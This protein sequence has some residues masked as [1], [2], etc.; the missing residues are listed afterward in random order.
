M[1][2][3]ILQK[4]Y[5]AN[6]NPD[7]LCYMPPDAAT[8][9]EVGC[10]AGALGRAF[11]QRN[12]LGRYIGVEIFSE[13]ADI[14]RQDLDTVICGDVEA[15]SLESILQADE[16]IDCIVYGDVLEHMKDPWRVL[17]AQSDFLSDEGQVLACIPNVQ[18]WR[19]IG[20]LIGGQWE[21]NEK[22]VQ[23]KNHLR[24][25]TLDEIVKLF[26]QAGLQIYEII[27]RVYDAPPNEKVFEVLLGAAKELG[28]PDNPIHKVRLAASQFVVR[29]G[30]QLRP[31]PVLLHAL[32]G[33]TMVCSRVRISEPHSFCATVPG[34]KAVE[35]IS[36]VNEGPAGRDDENKVFFWQRVA[37]ESF[38][39]YEILLRRGYLMISE[40]DDHPM[41]APK[42]FSRNNFES[43]RACHAVQVS[44]EP[45]AGLMRQYNPNVAVF[46]NQI[47][48]LPAPRKYSEGPIRLFFGALNREA[49]WPEIIPVID[50]CLSGSSHEVTVIHDRKFYDALATKNK[51]FVPVCPFAQYR[52][53][54]SQTDIAF[55][56]L[57]DTPFNRMKSDLKFLE[58]A[59]NGVVALASPVVYENSIR[60]GDTGSLYRSP[61][62]FGEKL[63]LL[64]RDGELRRRIAANA[65]QWVKHNR[66]LSQ[67][68]RARLEWYQQLRSRY[69]ELTEEIYHRMN[70]RG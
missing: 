2:W 12:P 20:K 66:M 68:Y 45:L 41:V 25:F 4:K 49:D 55:L 65:Y 62:E 34:V 9:L 67:H 6:V 3:L 5:Y 7:I 44:T 70:Q 57:K 59:A 38:A 28:I 61:K 24:F 13:A 64:M 11:K 21:Y 56:P 19:V 63:S 50:K 32:L 31:Q 46:L 52:E 48:E 16:K 69:A 33:E 40:F 39:Q 18:H 1:G 42:E 15:I 36:I 54:L 53:L 29:A 30:K 35:D 8:V 43:F 37:P 27:P 23:D 47:A 26:A 17:K 22:G 58:C 10:G 14:A 60:D 51:R